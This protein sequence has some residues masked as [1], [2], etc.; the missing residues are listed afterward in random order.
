MLIYIVLVHLI[1]S[2]NKTLCNN[3]N[4]TA[5]EFDDDSIKNDD[6][7]NESS[8]EKKMLLHRRLM[9]II[10]M[11]RDINELEKKYNETVSNEQ[12]ERNNI[13]PGYVLYEL[14]KLFITILIDNLHL[15]CK[16]LTK[17]Y[18]HLLNNK[19]VMKLTLFARCLIALMGSSIDQITPIIV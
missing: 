15:I 19:L 13:D 1:L 14:C 3:N 8:K 9:R 6:A 11:E 7:S 4:K 16:Q 5:I 2:V 10:D 18:I 17:Q 12:K